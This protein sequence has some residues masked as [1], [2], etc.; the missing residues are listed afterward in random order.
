MCFDPDHREAILRGYAAGASI[1][2]LAMTTGC[3]RATIT[4]LLESAG[5]QPAPRGRGRPRVARRT[6]VAEWMQETIRSLYVEQRLSRRQIAERLGIGEHTVRST[7]QRAAVQTRTRGRLNREDRT[8]LSADHARHLYID[9]RLTIAATADRLGLGMSVVAASLHEAGVGVR[10]PTW[11]EPDE[12]VH[13]LAELYTDPAVLEV[14]DRHSVPRRPDP[15]YLST[16]FPEPV[17]PH[18][19]LLRDLYEEVG[20]AIIHIELLTGLPTTTIRRRLMKFGIPRRRPGGLCPW[21]RSIS[22]ITA[23]PA[24]PQTAGQDWQRP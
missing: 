19:Q 15:G 11:R 13:V 22:G 4:K 3:S 10:R 1:R 20:L 23:S 21:R 2:Q 5:L 18:E 14:L 7:L 9:R 12:Y 24:S 6:T 8:R 17:S 16:R